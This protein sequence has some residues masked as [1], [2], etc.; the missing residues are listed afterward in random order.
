MIFF[1]LDVL[2][3]DFIYGNRITVKTTN[4][5]NVRFVIDGNFNALKDPFMTMSI[6]KIGEIL[7]IDNACLRNDGN[8]QGKIS[9]HATP[10][11]KF[12]LSAEDNRNETGKPLRSGIKF[13]F[14]ANYSSLAM[15]TELDIVSG[16]LFYF[17]VMKILGNHW[18]IGCESILSAYDSSFQQ[19]IKDFN[20]QLLY[21][22]DDYSVHLRTTSN[23]QNLKANYLQNISKNIMLASSI[24]YSLSNNF[25]KLTVGTQSM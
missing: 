11:F 7:S 17:S 18:T 21:R 22:G 14:D 5:D 19:T 12:V 13:G 3:E 15:Q 8:V 2:N 1:H 20:V 24:D 25:Q 4:H 23:L 16:S 6:S 10:N 9:V